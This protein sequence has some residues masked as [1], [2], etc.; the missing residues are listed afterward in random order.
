MKDLLI[1][2]LR[3]HFS[4]DT[5]LGEKQPVVPGASF[6]AYKLPLS[7]RAFLWL[8]MAGPWICGLLLLASLGLEGY[9]DWGGGAESLRSFS[10]PF[11][12]ISVSGLIGYGTNYIAIRMLFKPVEKRPILGQGLIP[13]QRERI[14]QVLAKGMH[15]HILSPELIRNRIEKT[16]F[17][18]K[19]ADLSVDGVKGLTQ[20]IEL[21][22][23]LKSNLM[24]QITAFTSRPEFRREIS[25]V[26]DK[27]L[28][29]SLA[30]GFKRF[31]LQTYKRVNRED[32]EST[33]DQIVGGLPKALLE[34]ADR[35]E[36]EIDRVGEFMEQQRQPIEAGLMNLFV[37]LL[38]RIDIAGLLA[39]QMEHFD[40]QRLERMIWSAT[41]EQLLYI[42]NLGTLLGVIGGFV[43]WRP[44]ESGLTI[45]L[46]GGLVWGLD[47]LLFRMK[48]APRPSSTLPR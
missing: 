34:V 47:E 36:A 38:D 5:L 21:R 9:I 27:Q 44:L 43:I 39:K 37:N 19:I 41:N 16:G 25:A 35:M 1:D 42:Q 2:S 30:D 12:A 7:K 13:S 24:E 11:I 8:L 18:K 14:I 31:M 3:R 17:T 40:E 22:K 29:L 45:C 6:N 4:F 10:E 33:I 32:Y 20:D 23:A 46:L 48:P 15:E 26:I 28:E